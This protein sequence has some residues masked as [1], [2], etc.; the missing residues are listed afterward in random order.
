MART[1]VIAGLSAVAIAMTACATNSND[2]ASEPASTAV[3]PAPT[4]NAPIGSTPVPAAPANTAPS[5]PTAP[6]RVEGTVVRFATDDASVDVTI[7]SDNPTT[8]D[9][10]STLPL[11]LS[12]EEFN[13]REKVAY[14][15]RKLETEGSSGYDPVDGDLI[16]FAP[17]GNLGFYYDA[18]GIGFS[19]QVIHLGTY[20]ASVDHLAQLEDRDVTVEIVA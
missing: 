11:T 10:L 18:D 15:P 6:D 17:W 7:T 14:L 4:S 19:D 5:Q 9:F 1:M 13:G 20:D 3:P 2:G 12:V 8:R 16:Y